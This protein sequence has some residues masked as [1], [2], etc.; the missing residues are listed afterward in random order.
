MSLFKYILI[1][2]IQ[3]LLHTWILHPL[4]FEFYPYFM[5]PVVNFAQ[6]EQ[7]CHS[8]GLFLTYGSRAFSPYN[9]HI[10]ILGADLYLRHAGK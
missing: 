6:D 7:R 1:I 10:V 3:G 9:V 2:D 4:L 5:E 8:L